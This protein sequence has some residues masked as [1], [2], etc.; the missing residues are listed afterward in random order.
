M[1][2]LTPAQMQALNQ[3]AVIGDPR[4]TN[5]G[6]VGFQD[7]LER[8][9]GGQPVTQMTQIPTLPPG[10]MEEARR[11]LALNPQDPIA[12]Y[13]V[14]YAQRG[15]GTTPAPQFPELP[16]ELKAIS[17]FDDLNSRDQINAFYA[18]PEAYYAQRGGGAGVPGGIV[19]GDFST[20]N[21]A[22]QGGGTGVPDD[23]RQPITSKYK[24][25]TGTIPDSMAA[26][27]ANQGGGMVRTGEFIDTNRNGVDD[28]DEVGMTPSGAPASDFVYS[29]SITR[30]ESQM[31]PITQQLLFGLGG[32]G[33]FIP[34]AMRAA[35]R[36]FFDEQGR[37]RV[38]PQEIA[39]FSPDQMRAFQMARQVGGIQTPYLQEAQRQYGMGIGALGESQKQALMAQRRALADIQSGAATEEQLREAGLGDILGATEEARR[40]ALGAE[41]ELRG[42]LGGIEGIQRGAAGA[43]GRELGDIAGMVRGST[44]AFDPRTGIQAYMDPFEEQVVQQTISDVME[45]GAQQ[46]IAARAGDIARGGESAFGSRARLGAAERQRALG[47]GLG[48]AIGALRSGGFQQAQQRAMGEFARQQEQQR[49]AAGQLGNIAGSQLAAQTGLA[50]QLGEAARQRYAAGTGA[51]ETILGLGQVGAGAQMGAGQAALGTAQQLAGAQQAL[52]G[53]YGQLGAQQLGARA[54]Y[55]GFLSGLGQQAQAGQLAGIQAL[56][57][58]GAMQ[59]QQQQA[60]LDAQRQAALQAQAAPLAQ[61]QALMPFISMAPTGTTQISTQFAPPPSPLQAGIGTGLATLGALGNL[62]NPQ[63]T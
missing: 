2:M 39:G 21:L 18:N 19:A 51:G 62:F 27:R 43:F 6:S 56:S 8:Y 3:R 47:R 53:L 23:I 63:R 61:Y 22:N 1:G 7:Y 60:I 45:R 26:N 35:E 52:G 31:D 58:A 55:G 17:Q 13:Y 54:G 48:E 15:G 12:N 57:G 32:Q 24:P 4:I 44:G 37:A 29:P 10:E 20:A 14:N 30:T 5:Q 46:D 38:I 59:Q 28:R 42:A 34:G 11:R 49:A 33:G 41:T 40:R 16:P 9:S 50:G 25:G 36:T